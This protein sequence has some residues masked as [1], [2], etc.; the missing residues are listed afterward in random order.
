M[1]M[2]AAAITAAV[3][4]CANHLRSAGITYH[5]AHGVLV[6]VSICENA[7]W[8]SSQCPRSRTSAAENFQFFSGTSIRLRK[9]TRC[10]SFERLRNSLT[11]L[12]PLSLR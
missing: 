7:F 12:K 10:S 11:I 3:Q 5:G 2:R 6:A 9:R 8:Y 1:S 4:T